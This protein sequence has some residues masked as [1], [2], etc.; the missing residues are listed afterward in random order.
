MASGTGPLRPFDTAEAIGVVIA[1]HNRPKLVGAAIESVLA[2]TY[3][4]PIEVV[5]VFDRAD[6]DPSLASDDPRRRI[7]VCRNSRTA[8]LAGARNTGILALDTELIAF[9]DDDDA[10]LEGKLAAQLDRLAAQ[11]AAQFITTAMQVDYG[12]RSTVRL[13]GADRVNITYLVRSRMAMLHSSS[14]LFRRDAMLGP[15]GFGLVDETMPGSMAEDWD[16]LI[17]ASRRR[18]IEHLD[19]PLVRVLW[20]ASS[21]FNDAWADKNEAHRW[22]IEHHPEIRADRIALGLQLGKLAFGHAALR[23][24]RE[25]WRYVRAALHTNWREPRTAFA[26]LVLLGLSPGWVTGHLNKRGHGI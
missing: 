11:P 1:T 3:A 19:E 7:R 20:G 5:V 9:C 16:L 13:A 4:G 6:P 15:D 17:R 26:L 10:W 23:Q 2:Q 14:F 25:A 12:D 24:R 21:Y 22:L 18:P 8:G